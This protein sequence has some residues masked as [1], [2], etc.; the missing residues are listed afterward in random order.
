MI[1]NNYFFATEKLSSDEF[2]TH[3]NYT[4][5]QKIKN[6]SKEFRNRLEGLDKGSLIRDILEKRTQLCNDK[7]KKNTYLKHM[8]LY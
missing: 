6:L 1:K 5:N 8:I 7:T 4:N 3:W 2:S